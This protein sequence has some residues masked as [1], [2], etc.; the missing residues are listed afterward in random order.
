MGAVGGLYGGRLAAAGHDVHFL[1]RSSLDEIRRDGLH[2]ES[3]DGDIDLPTVS[4]FDRAED[5]P[6]V[7]VVVIATK[8]TANASLAGTL[9]VL[10]RPGT[11]VVVMQNGLGGEEQASAFAPDAVIL[12]GLCFVCSELLDPGHVRH[13]DYGT[14]TLGTFRSDGRPAGSTPELTAVAQDLGSAGVKVIPQ[15]D[16]VLARWKKL[17]WNIPYNGLSVVLDA[18]TDELMA[19]PA[20]RTLVRSL[21]E[22]VVAGAA[23]CRRVIEERFVEQMLVDTDAMTPYRTS[24]K[25]DFDAR[26]PLEIDAIYGT[27]TI[28]ARSAGSPMPRT[29]ALADELRF[30]DTRNRR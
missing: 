22:E 7:D 9:P 1:V 17:V 29:E 14:V 20:S 10:I 6:P 11:T 23:T 25:L 12:G 30:L 13:V 5:V 4:V 16:L 24:M 21:M 27:P 26:R 8:T 28:R 2:V 3:V 18:G 19:D 15:D